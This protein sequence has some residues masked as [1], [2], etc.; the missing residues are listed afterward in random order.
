MCDFTTLLW[1]AMGVHW[2]L[3]EELSKLTTSRLKIRCM[4]VN[5]KNAL[6]TGVENQ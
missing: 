1:H 6:L 5:Q 2:G 3:R 4:K